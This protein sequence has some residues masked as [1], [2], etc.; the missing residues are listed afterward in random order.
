MVHDMLTTCSFNK[1][2]K[3]AVLMAAATINATSVSP[4]VVIPP[5]QPITIEDEETD[6]DDPMANAWAHVEDD[7][8]TNARRQA[9]ERLGPYISVI[10]TFQV[11]R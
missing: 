10:K 2:F 6:R 9:E 8:M 3:S 1:N 5:V 4:R 11:D 7:P